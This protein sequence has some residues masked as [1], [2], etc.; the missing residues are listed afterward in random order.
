[1]PVDHALRIQE[2]L[3]GHTTYIIGGLLIAVGIGHN[4]LAALFEVEQCLADSVC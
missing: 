2:N 4:P 3:V 1:M